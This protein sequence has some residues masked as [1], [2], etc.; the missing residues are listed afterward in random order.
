MSIAGFNRQVVALAWGT[1]KQA[2]GSV[3]V[4]SLFGGRYAGRKKYN[5]IRSPLFAQN[6]K[7]G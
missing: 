7:L 4:R 3:A 2:P 1:A 5:I 6:G